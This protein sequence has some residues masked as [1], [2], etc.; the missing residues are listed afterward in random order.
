VPAGSS[1][2][3]QD[4][5]W[6]AI[7]VAHNTS[8]QERRITAKTKSNGKTQKAKRKTNANAMLKYPKP[9]QKAKDDFDFCLLRFAF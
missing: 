8:T 2:D 5:H 9:S 7:F 6:R 4:A 3:H 1:R